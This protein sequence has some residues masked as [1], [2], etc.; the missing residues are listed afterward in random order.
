MDVSVTYS[1][2]SDDLRNRKSSRIEKQPKTQEQEEGKDQL[3]PMKIKA[4]KYKDTMPE[5]IG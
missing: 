4:W 3:Q 1:A 2:G 5:Q